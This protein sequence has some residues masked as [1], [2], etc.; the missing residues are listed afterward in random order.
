MGMDGRRLDTFMQYL[1]EQEFQEDY[2][3]RR[4]DPAKIV[5]YMSGN[6]DFISPDYV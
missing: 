5:R 2:P 3:S 6:Q 1:T 4:G